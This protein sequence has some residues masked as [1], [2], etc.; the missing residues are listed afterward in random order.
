MKPLTDV[1]P[2]PKKVLDL[3]PEELGQHVLGC[4][5][6]TKEPNIERAIIAKTLSS[7]YHESFQHEIAHAVEEALAWLAAQCLFATSPYDQNLI[8][9][10][11]RGKKVAA[12]YRASR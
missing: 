9:L 11:R 12:D 10:T 7:N 5:S 2:D 1:Y 4:L 3:E 8:F 6:G